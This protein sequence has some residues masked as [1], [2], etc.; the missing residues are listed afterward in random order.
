MVAKVAADASKRT[1]EVQALVKGLVGWTEKT[2]WNR[3]DGTLPHVIPADPATG[4]AKDLVLYENAVIFAG[5]PVGQAGGQQPKLSFLQV[6]EMI[7]IGDAWKFV[8]LPRAID[9]EKPVVAAT[10]GLRAAIYEVAGGGGLPQQDPAMEAALKA[11]ADYDKANNA[12]ASAAARRKK[13][14]SSTSDGFRC[15]GASSRRPRTPTRSSATTS[16]SSTAW[17]PPTR[18]GPTRKAARCST[19]SSPRRTRSPRTPPSAPSAPSS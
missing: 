6:P 18:P 1:A 19:A 16:R 11:L 3:F 8:E 7:K 4:V 13:S 14:P 17:S 9:P 10:A 12:L 15:S 5:A 2:V